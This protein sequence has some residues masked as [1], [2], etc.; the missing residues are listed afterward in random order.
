[1]TA[2]AVARLFNLARKM[3]ESYRSP[4][5]GSCDAEQAVLQ[6]M[7]VVPHA[8]PAAVQMPQSQPAAGHRKK[9]K[10]AQPKEQPQQNQPA[11]KAPKGIKG[12]FYRIFPNRDDSKFDKVRKILLWVCLCVFIGSITYWWILVQQ[13]KKSQEN[14]AACK[15][16]WKKPSKIS[17]RMPAE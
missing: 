8:Q 6:G 2:D 11:P 10:K 7:D 16:R 4:P 3:L 1:M 9:G 15:A 13:N 14:I 12:I 17:A 5:Q